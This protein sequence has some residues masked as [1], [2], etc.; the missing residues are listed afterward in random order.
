MC[1][2]YVF[3][4][5]DKTAVPTVSNFYLIFENERRFYFVYWRFCLHNQIH[6]TII[7][8]ISVNNFFCTLNYRPNYFVSFI[9]RLDITSYIHGIYLHI[10][11]TVFSRFQCHYIRLSPI[12]L[13][14]YSIL[15]ILTKNTM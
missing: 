3:F 4:C 13:P 8:S 6:F 11:C 14:H 10:F 12:V 1:I 5:S 2:F 9:L 15:Y 7:I